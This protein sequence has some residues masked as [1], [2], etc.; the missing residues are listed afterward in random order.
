MAIVLLTRQQVAL[1]KIERFLRENVG[2]GITNPQYL[3]GYLTGAIIT[4]RR[5]KAYAARYGN[6]KAKAV[7]TLMRVIKPAAER[8][9][10]GSVPAG[11]DLGDAAIE[12]AKMV[13]CLASAQPVSH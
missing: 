13:W 11:I 6:G 4:N 12:A 10:G 8:F 2:M 7:D 5:A 9:F 1:R 3:N